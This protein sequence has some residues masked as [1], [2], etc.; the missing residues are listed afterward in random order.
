MA[1]SKAVVE[2]PK[3]QIPTSEPPPA[4]DEAVAEEPLTPLRTEELLTELDTCQAR[5]SEIKVL[6]GLAAPQ[7]IYPI[8]H[9]ETGAILGTDPAFPAFQ[10]G[11]PNPKSMW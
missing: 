9:P 4:V 11:D 6:L 3:Q 5:A 8:R 10:G 7:S 1:Y 2:E